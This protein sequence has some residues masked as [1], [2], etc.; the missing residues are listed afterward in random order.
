MPI[1]P[2]ESKSLFI[3]SF[4]DKSNTVMLNKREIVSV[5]QKGNYS[6]VKTTAGDTFLIGRPLPE[7]VILLSDFEYK[8]HQ[9]S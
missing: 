5:V 4:D 2:F 1:Q 6:E 7:L 3:Q 9:E 8:T